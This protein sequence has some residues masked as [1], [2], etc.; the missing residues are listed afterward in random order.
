MDNV[1]ERNNSVCI[2]PYWRP[3]KQSLS[4]EKERWGHSPVNL[5]GLNNCLPYHYLKMEDLRFVRNLL[6]Q[7][8]FYEYLVLCSTP[9]IWAESEHVQ[10]TLFWARYRL[11]IFKNQWKFPV[12]RRLEISTIAYFNMFLISLNGENP[13]GPIYIN[14]SVVV[15]LIV[16]S[17]WRNQTSVWFW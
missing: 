6:Q 8:N 2:I 5:K 12:S 3:Y 17:F 16:I 15:S 4:D 10:I 11:R 1:D 7:N 14:I 9:Q 13:N